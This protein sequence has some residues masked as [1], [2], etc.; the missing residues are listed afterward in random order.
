[1]TDVQRSQEYY[2]LAYKCHEISN[3]KNGCNHQC[4][5]CTLNIHLYID[6]VREATLIK[7][8]AGIDYQRSQA[9]QQGDTLNRWIVFSCIVLFIF[10]P[11]GLITRCTIRYLSPGDPVPRYES[12]FYTA[13]PEVAERVRRAALIAWKPGD[14][15][16]DGKEDCVDSALMFYKIYGPEAKILW[17]K[18]ERPKWNHLFIGVPNGYGNFVFIEATLQGDLNYVLLQNAW[19]RENI[20]QIDKARD[21]TMHYK[22]ILNRTYLWRW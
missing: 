2:R 17:I 4:A 11:I 18:T 20:D 14:I 15:N 12:Q 1:M 16:K 8:S 10:V 7:T 19:P 21:V 13:T 22:E 6:D 5:A 9:M 3:T